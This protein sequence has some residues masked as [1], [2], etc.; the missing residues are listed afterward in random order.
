[1]EN[2]YSRSTL[3][4]HLRNTE[5][6]GQRWEVSPGLGIEGFN[7]NVATLAA[8]ERLSQNA[9]HYHE[10]Q[11]EFFHVIEGRCRVEVEDGS[12]T[13]EADELV[14]FDAGA[15]HLIH[16]PFEERCKLVAIGSPPD[17]RFPVH[18]VQSYE[19]L[20]EERYPDGFDADEHDE[21]DGDDER[22]ERDE[23]R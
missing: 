1:M 3:D 17:G 12:F 21:H 10:N 2:G 23:G 16:N 4:E 7:Y 13:L 5:K 22:G 8:G 14:R 11:E 18:Q 20:L 15:P 9:Y 19:S 6:P